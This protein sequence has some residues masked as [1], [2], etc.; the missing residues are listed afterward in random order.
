MTREALTETTARD[1][2]RRPQRPEIPACGPQ[3]QVAE[4]GTLLARGYLRLL[5]RKA[6]P[7]ANN[8]AQDATDSGQTRLDDVGKESVHGDG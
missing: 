1:A 4:I 8:G 5:A 7:G 2:Q 3:G 6:V